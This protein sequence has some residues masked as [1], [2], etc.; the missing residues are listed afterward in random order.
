MPI[1]P[2]APTLRGPALSAQHWDDL[3]FLHWPV[4]PASIAGFFP[5]GVRPDVT[6]GVSYVGLVPFRMRG[7]GPGRL[8]VPYFGSFCETNV[9]LYSVDAQDRHGIVFLT[10]DATRLATVLLARVSLGLPYAWSAMSYRRHDDEITY[11]SIRRWPDRSRR[12]GGSVRVRVGGTAEPTELEVWLTA[13]WGLHTRVA[14]QTVWVPNEHPPWPLRTA[15]LLDL[16]CDLVAACGVD[17]D[18]STMLRPLWSP[19]VRTTFG[20]PATVES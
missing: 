16:D 14:G 20:P 13:R 9:R 8:P 11:R 19:G 12:A 18:P 10:L 15:Q 7:A 5:A 1:Q 4:D 3:C 2:L 6:D 17:V